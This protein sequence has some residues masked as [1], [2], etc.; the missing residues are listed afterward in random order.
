MTPVPDFPLPLT[1]RTLRDESGLAPR[2]TVLEADMD[3][4]RNAGAHVLFVEEH[5]AADGHRSLF[6]TDPMGRRYTAALEGGSSGDDGGAS[7]AHALNRL[8]QLAGG[9]IA[10]YPHGK[11]CAVLRAIAPTP[12]IDIRWLAYLTPA[13]V[14]DARLR[15]SRDVS[16]HLH[17]LE[18][19]SLHILREAA[20]EGRRSARRPAARRDR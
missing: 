1:A 11:L 8:R 9:P 17:R 12:D 4:A 15:R 19:E 3:R 6:A 10:V 2:G 7:L 20:A 18:A 5:R 13:P 14:I 16:P